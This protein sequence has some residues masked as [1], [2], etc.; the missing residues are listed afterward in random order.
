MHSEHQPAPSNANGVAWLVNQYSRLHPACDVLGKA[1][2]NNSTD[3]AGVSCPGGISTPRN[4]MEEGKNTKRKQA[5]Q[6]ALAAMEKQ[7]AAF[8]AFAAE[9]VT[10]SLGLLISK[11]CD[12]RVFQDDMSD[13]DEGSSDDGIDSN[14]EH[15]STDGSDNKSDHT[16]DDT[17]GGTPRVSTGK[18]SGAGGTKKNLG[19][20][21]SGV[22]EV[23]IFYISW[24]F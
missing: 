14:T 11:Y 3:E 10:I 15:D 6:K 22:L 24:I 2:G 23:R 12:V 9:M 19:R 1:H 4:S 20:S 7:Q 21:N 13:S 17:G 18:H 16:I 5:Q 8:A